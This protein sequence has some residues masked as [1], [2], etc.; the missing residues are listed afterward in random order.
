MTTIP[1]MTDSADANATPA[2]APSGVA[3][4]VERQLDAGLSERA[5][6]KNADVALLD[7]ISSA[8]TSA[9]WE[10]A[11]QWALESS[12]R[13][14]LAAL[15]EWRSA[16]LMAR[17]VQRQNLD[18]QGI[19]AGSAAT[20]L[21]AQ[22]R[23]IAAMFVSAEPD[24]SHSANFHVGMGFALGLLLGRGG[25]QP[26]SEFVSFVVRVIAEPDVPFELRPLAGAVG[27]GLASTQ[28]CV[29]L[30]RA[31]IQRK[32]VDAPGFSTFLI[33]LARSGHAEA[34]VD[35][36]RLGWLPA[37]NERLTFFSNLS[38]HSAPNEKPLQEIF[39]SLHD[40]GWPWD[41]MSLVF[42]WSSLEP[43]N[44]RDDREKHALW[45]MG[46]KGF[47][48]QFLSDAIAL[49]C[50]G[51]WT[52]AP[53]FVNFALK[54]GVKMPQAAWNKAAESWSVEDLRELVKASP[55]WDRPTET[56]WH[57]AVANTPQAFGVIARAC[58]FTADERAYGL[59]CLAELG[60]HEWAKKSRHLKPKAGLSP[61]QLAWSL[62]PA[63]R[64]QRLSIIRDLLS[65]GADPKG[66]LG[67]GA[68]LKAAL[69]DHAFLAAR[70]LASQG[71][72]GSAA[73][74]YALRPRK[75]K[76]ASMEEFVATAL[77]IRES[78]QL[79]Q[80]VKAAKKS[81]ANQSGKQ[82]SSLG[83]EIDSMADSGLPLD[84]PNRDNANDL[85][86]QKNRMR[87]L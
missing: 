81:T 51:R 3:R 63:A 15:N 65:L 78:R 77:S 47:E 10:A 46:Q 40:A 32:G 62:A 73:V 41:A 67:D 29:E 12:P 2:R 14:A 86:P 7:V 79:A 74:A 27:W 48:T 9:E 59:V 87:R 37:E 66:P 43:Q 56:L 26:V 76:S 34:A 30:T 75:G 38:G 52:T 55:Q 19:E 82:L 68:P 60:E 24:L 42:A 80:T 13:G 61:Q 71:G 31:I 84:A 22:A 85:G 33:S 6:R 83:R 54:N 64:G 72:W 21:L 49:V 18:E 57:H 8:D 28:S 5:R 53:Q 58:P 25:E 17:P 45:V 20:R 16:H 4:A 36:A 35:A 50:S 39:T 70:H 44:S 1:P 11:R 69:M 23:A